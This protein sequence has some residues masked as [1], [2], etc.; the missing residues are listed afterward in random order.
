MSRLIDPT[1]HPPEGTTSGRIRAVILILLAATVVLPVA[2]ATG[3]PAH[4]ASVRTVVLKSIALHPATVRIGVGGTV[5]WEFRDKPTPHNVTST[6]RHRF[7]SSPTRQ[8][9]SY[10][11]RFTKRGTYRYHCTIHPS[12]QGKVVVG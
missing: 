9:G 8:A 2:G 5:R 4:V 1:L 11:V 6:G 3:E 7:A 12:M 10:S